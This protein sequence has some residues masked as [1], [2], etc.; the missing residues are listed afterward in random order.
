LPKIGDVRSGGRF[1][2]DVALQHDRTQAAA[3]ERSQKFCCIAAIRFSG[4]CGLE[5]QNG[6]PP[7]SQFTRQASKFGLVRMIDVID[8]KMAGNA[9]K[10]AQKTG[11]VIF[12][13]RE[14]CVIVKLIE[15]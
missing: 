4:G 6:I 1:P 2:S 12:W 7:F 14:T 3:Q 15:F 9:R 10:W 11:I 8:I 5:V 13:W